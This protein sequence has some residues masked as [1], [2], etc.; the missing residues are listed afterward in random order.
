MVMMMEG[1]MITLISQE[2]LNANCQHKQT[3][4][5]HPDPDPLVNVQGWETGAADFLR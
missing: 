2:R 1:R 4:T 5:N 3:R